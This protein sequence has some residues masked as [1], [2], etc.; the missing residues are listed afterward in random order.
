MRRALDQGRELPPN[1]SATV[2]KFSSK[3]SA[4][5]C[6]MEIIMSVCPLYEFYKFMFM[7]NIFEKNVLYKCAT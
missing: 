5:I 4:H 6:K 1:S 3:L 2:D 7:V